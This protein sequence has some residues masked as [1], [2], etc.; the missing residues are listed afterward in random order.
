MSPEASDGD[1]DAAAATRP[2]RVQSPDWPLPAARLG[3]RRGAERPAV[4]AAAAAVAELPGCA[5][6]GASG[7]RDPAL[8]QA[9]APMHPLP[10]ILNAM[11][12]CRAVPRPSSCLRLG[13]RG[14][15]G[16][17]RRR[18]PAGDGVVCREGGGGTV[19]EA[20]LLAGVG[21]SVADGI[22][23]HTCSGNQ[24]C[25]QFRNRRVHPRMY[26]QARGRTISRARSL[27][28]C[29]WCACENGMRLTH[30]S[31]RNGELPCTCCEGAG[32]NARAARM[33][34]PP[35]QCQPY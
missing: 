16:Q 14:A 20:F 5:V 22:A 24:A 15:E 29:Q 35:C 25:R 11:A 33:L 1:E 12:T 28:A 18:T 21:G 7:R 26:R 4:A 19:S 23:A 32:G 27:D 34:A 8:R 9:C 13:R 30:G 2:R 3:P 6:A 17:W 31:R 10:C